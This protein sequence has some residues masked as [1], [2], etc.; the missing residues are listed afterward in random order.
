ME[1]QTTSRDNKKASIQGGSVFLE[2]SIDSGA[3]IDEE[4]DLKL[5]MQ[6]RHSL[7]DNQELAF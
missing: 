4:R 2:T 3:P 5:Q 1:G 7:A 6:K